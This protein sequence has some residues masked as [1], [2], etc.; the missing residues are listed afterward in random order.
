MQVLMCM[1]GVP[2]DP[3]KK[4]PGRPSTGRTVAKSKEWLVLIKDKIPAYIT[5]EQYERNLRQL[6]ANSMQGIGVPRHGP[7]LLS[8]LLICGRCGLRM[9]T[10]YTNNGNKLRYGCARMSSDYGDPVCQS[11]IG[12][13]LDELVKTQVLEALKPSALDVSLQVAEDIENERK[14]LFTHW[15]KQLERAR[16]EAE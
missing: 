15:E 6:V 8:G 1:G 16:Y 14:N 9:A 4:K 2:T 13:A 11:L 3:R 12:N 7:S 10:Y 5:W